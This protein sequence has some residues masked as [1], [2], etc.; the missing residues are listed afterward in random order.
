MAPEV[1]ISEANLVVDLLWTISSVLIIALEV[2]SLSF[3][4]W[5]DVMDATSGVSHEMYGS[6]LT[7]RARCSD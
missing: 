4:I 2:S 7:I 1:A 3:S 6:P 5:V